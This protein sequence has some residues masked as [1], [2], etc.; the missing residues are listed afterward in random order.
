M[1][2]QQ[3]LLVFPPDFPKDWIRLFLKPGFNGKVEGIDEIVYYKVETIEV[4]PDGTPAD[5]ELFSEAVDL[6]RDG[7]TVI[8]QGQP[9]C[10]GKNTVL[11]IGHDT[12]LVTDIK[13]RVETIQSAY[14]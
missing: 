4:W 13:T 2:K 7:D 11:Y 3:T 8:I 10:T 1:N 12:F 9:F 5:L 6:A 14:K